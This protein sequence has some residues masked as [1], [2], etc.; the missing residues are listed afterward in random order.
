[1]RTP[2]RGLGAQERLEREQERGR[3]LADQVQ[4]QARRILELTDKVEFMK[5]Y[6]ELCEAKIQ[7]LCRTRP[8]GP[9]RGSP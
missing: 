3:A 2:A 9:R 8:A 5:G 4:E 1:M 6:R 7:A